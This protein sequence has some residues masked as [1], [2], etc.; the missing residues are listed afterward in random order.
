VFSAG[1]NAVITVSDPEGTVVSSM[2]VVE[3]RQPYLSVTMYLRQP[4]Q[5]GDTYTLRI[6]LSREEVELD[7]RDIDFVLE[8][9]QDGLPGLDDCRL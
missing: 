1:P 2:F 8:F 9:A 7:R 6:E 4:P 3:M 5:P